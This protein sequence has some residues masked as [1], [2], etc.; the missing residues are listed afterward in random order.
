MKIK[1]T[2]RIGNQVAVSSHF[3]TYQIL[4][5][6]FKTFLFNIVVFISDLNVFILNFY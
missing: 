6:I 1:V 5:R 3:V 4:A 2:F